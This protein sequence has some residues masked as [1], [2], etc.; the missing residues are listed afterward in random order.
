MTLVL[1]ARNPTDSVTL[2]L[3]PAAHRA[4]L[5]VRVL[6]DDPVEEPRAPE[7]AFCNWFSTAAAARAAVLLLALVAL[8]VVLAVVVVAA[9]G[10]VAALTL[11]AAVAWVPLTE[12]EVLT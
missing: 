4:G 10:A 5:P 3:L 11:V 7:M 1:L 12:P 2:G 9:A 6:T 8:P